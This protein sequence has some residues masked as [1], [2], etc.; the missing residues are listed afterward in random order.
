[1]IARRCDTQEKT[2]VERGFFSATS[3]KH[4]GHSPTNRDAGK[5][6]SPLPPLTL[7]QVASALAC[8]PAN[9]ERSIWYSI[10]AA[11]RRE[12]GDVAF[13]AFDQWSATGDTYRRVDC[14]ATWKSVARLTA[15]SIGTLLH[16]AKAHGWT[17]PRRYPLTPAEQARVER[18]TIEAQRARE[19]RNKIAAHELAESQARA[20]KRAAAIWDECVIES[21]SHPYL[22]AKK[23]ARTGQNGAF[24]AMPSTRR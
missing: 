22:V 17:A 10:A 24:V 8:I 16:H 5:C 14:R 13:D 9:V 11:L 7:Q 20:A 21:G 3:S 2:P 18:E 4:I 6:F 23:S 12:H 19:T 1:M 15:Y